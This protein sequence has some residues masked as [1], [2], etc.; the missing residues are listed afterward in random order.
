MAEASPS[1]PSEVRTIVVDG[2]PAHYIEMCADKRLELGEAASSRYGFTAE[3]WLALNQNGALG[4]AY[5]DD[6]HSKTPIGKILSTHLT[7]SETDGSEMLGAGAVIFRDTPRGR[8]VSDEVASGKLRTVSINY[9]TVIDQF[10]GKKVMQ[11]LIA[12][13]VHPNPKL[14]SCTIYRRQGKNESEADKVKVNL[15]GTITRGHSEARSVSANTKDQGACQ[16]S[17]YDRKTV[18]LLF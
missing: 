13:G 6:A 9:K 8:Q 7:R 11:K 1:T 10:T 2:R 17:L 4:N 5:L 12:I 18:S 14:P 15:V 3:E 16:S